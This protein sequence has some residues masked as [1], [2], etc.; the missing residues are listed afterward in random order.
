MKIINRGEGKGKMVREE[1]E[2]TGKGGKVMR[3]N[4]Q[5][6]FKTKRVGN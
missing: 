4:Y 5:E 6:V 2:R 3:R 1:M